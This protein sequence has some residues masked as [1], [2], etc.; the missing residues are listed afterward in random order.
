VGWPVAVLAVGLLSCGKEDRTAGAEKASAPATEAEKT[1][2]GSFAA[3]NAPYAA[4][5][6]AKGFSVLQA[7]RFPTQL[8][9]R[10]ALVVVYG[11]RDGSRG[12]ILYVRGFGDESPRPVWHWYFRDGAPDSVQAA[13]L[14]RDG[15]WDVRVFMRGGTTVDYLQD[16]SFS[17]RGR[18]RGGLVAM[19]GGSSAPADIWKAFDADTA[20]AWRSPAAG[21]F[22]E[23]PNPFGLSTGELS[24]QLSGGSRPKKVA[25]FAGEKKVHE[26][27]LAPTREEQRFL[28]DPELK[29]AE[30][31]RV[32]VEGEGA[33]VAVSELEIQ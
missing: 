21:A 26:F 9:G 24:L 31:I 18:E 13:D 25:L 20:T 17:F 28:L 32:V 12:G 6:T 23:I 11:A 10:K 3:E 7:K 8:E 2:G 5:I 4:Q 16:Q 19:N 27:D 29:G 15:L 1:A 30:S 14:N 33:S 22:L